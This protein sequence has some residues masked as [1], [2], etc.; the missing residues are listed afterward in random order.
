MTTGETD[1][2]GGYE[3]AVGEFYDDC[4]AQ[5]AAHLDAG[6]DVA[7]LCEG[8]PFLYGSYMY[9]HD[10]LADRYDCRGDP[11]RDLVQRRRGRR[12]YPA[13]PP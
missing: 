11:R 9:L 4:A 2:P 3:A 5:L 12:G 8:D 13:R 6:R 7:V 1:H 10:R